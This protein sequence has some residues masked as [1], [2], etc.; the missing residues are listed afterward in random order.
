MDLK[1]TQSKTWETILPKCYHH[2]AKATQ[3]LKG[4][5]KVLLM[6]LIGSSKSESELKATRIFLRVFRVQL[7]VW[8]VWV[9]ASHT[10]LFLDRGM[11]R[12]RMKTTKSWKTSY[13]IQKPIETTSNR[14]LW[15]YPRQ[16]WLTCANKTKRRSLILQTTMRFVTPKIWALELDATNWG[17]LELDPSFSKVHKVRTNAPLNSN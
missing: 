1:T 8:V 2:L 13:K 10:M 7:A 17:G 3:I 4:V 15:T 12:P 11:T 6:L 14:T 5:V 9:I 16:K